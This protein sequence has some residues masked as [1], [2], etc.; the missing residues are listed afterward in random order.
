MWLTHN[1]FSLYFPFFLFWMSALLILSIY[2]QRRRSR[3]VGLLY[4]LW[5]LGRGGSESTIAQSLENVGHRRPFHTNGGRRCEFLTRSDWGFPI[6]SWVF[7]LFNSIYCCVLLLVVVYLVTNPITRVFLF[8]LFLF[9]FRSHH[10]AYGPYLNGCWEGG[11]EY[12]DQLLDWAA[13]Y[14]MPVLLDIHAH[15]DSQNGTDKYSTYWIET[16][17]KQKQT[18]KR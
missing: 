10:E 4:V 9:R 7:C 15:K 13:Q 17:Q 12:L 16:K 8:L 18:N 14:N 6:Y 1:S 11:L 3:R 5:G 2:W